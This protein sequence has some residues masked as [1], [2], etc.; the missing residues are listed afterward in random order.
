M[1]KDKPWILNVNFR[2]PHSPW[3]PIPEKYEYYR[4]KITLRDKY[5]QRESE[6]HVVD[7]E[8]SRHTADIF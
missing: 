1:P 7:R 5:L 3:H 6:L 8:Q 2:K 4:D